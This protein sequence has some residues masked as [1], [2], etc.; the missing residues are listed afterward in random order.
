MLPFSIDADVVINM[1]KNGALAAV[2]LVGVSDSPRHFLQRW[3]VFQ[4]R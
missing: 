3:A 2:A 4:P 1:V